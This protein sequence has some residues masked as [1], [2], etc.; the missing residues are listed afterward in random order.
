MDRF[1]RTGI[2]LL[3]AIALVRSLTAPVRGIL[4]GATACTLVVAVLL[5]QLGNFGHPS[6]VQVGLLQPVRFHDRL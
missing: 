2:F 4:M 6:A 1:D 3:L 5:G